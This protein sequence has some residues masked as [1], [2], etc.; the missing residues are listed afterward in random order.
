MNGLGFTISN[1]RGIK[2]VC[3]SNLILRLAAVPKIV[4]ISVD[5]RPASLNFESR[6]LTESGTCFVEPFALNGLNGEGQVSP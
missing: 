3:M 5:S 1:L 2:A 6:G 4:R